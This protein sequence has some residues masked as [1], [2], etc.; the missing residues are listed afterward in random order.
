MKLNYRELLQKTEDHVN[1]FYRDHTDENLFYHN[2]SHAVEVLRNAKKIAEHYHLDDRTFFI[3]CAAAC[4]ADSGYLIKSAESHILES[5][6]L[7]RAFLIT[8]DVNEPDIAAIEKCIVANQ[9]PQKPES[10]AEEIVCDAEL[11]Y[12]GTSDFAGK[13]ALL[14]METEALDAKIADNDWRE[15]SIRFLENHQYH[16]EYCRL[17]LNTGKANNLTEL[18]NSDETDKI[19]TVTNADLKDTTDENQKAGDGADENK[20][21]GKSN[22]KDQLLRGTQTMLR[23]TANKN[24]RISEMADNKASIMITVNSIIISV[25]FGLL[26]RTLNENQNLII[27]AI[28]LLIVNVGTIIFSVL[29]TRPKIAHGRFTSEDIANRSVNLLYFGSYY[30]MTFKEYDEGLKEMMNDR[31]FLYGSLS[32]DNYWQGKVLGRKYR[33]LRISYTIF[34]YGIVASVMAFLIAIIF[35]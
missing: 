14:R 15:S 8:L 6:K 18:R 20:R 29:A 10:F 23:I 25:I 24:I 21:T 22:E 3:V 13:N 33:L 12:L 7:A 34:L 11:F 5:V 17:I 16:T 1:L 27:P 30:K 19:I 4:F 32:K 35:F 28:M 9:I 31:D 26:A 2:H